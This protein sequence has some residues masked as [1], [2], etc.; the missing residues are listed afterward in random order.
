MDT[1]WVVTTGENPPVTGGG[2][3]ADL[4]EPGY[5]RLLRTGELRRRVDVAWRRLA[6]CDLCPR[7][8]HVDR[9]RTNRGAVCRTGARAVV[10]SFHPHF[11]EEACLVGRRGSGTIFFA[12]CNL[13]CQYCQNADLAH[14]GVGRVVEP[15]DLAA[16][17]LH[18]Q[19]EGCH[20]INLVTPSHVVPQILAAVA[21][22]AGRGLDRPLVYNTGGYDAVETLRL[23]DGVVDIYMPDMKYADAAV[24]REASRVRDYPAVNQAAV[25]EMYRQVGD[26]VL[27]ATGVAQR[28]LLVRHLVLPNGLAGT[29]AVVRFLAET[30]SPRTA[31]NVMDQYHPCFAA[32]RVPGLDRRPT[33]M[34]LAAARRL[35]AAAGLRRVG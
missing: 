15:A 22:A 34:E 32:W 27:D 7:D 12:W 30:V 26:L 25:L 5:R 6:D 23:L 17:M 24:G 9:R 20:N 19:D 8:C 28:G 33:A 10:A 35:V 1:R 29:A 21:I 4:A 14:R 18:L 31:V 13:R 2:C 16:M 3:G 11:G